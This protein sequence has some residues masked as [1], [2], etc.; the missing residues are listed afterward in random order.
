MAGRKRRRSHVPSLLPNVLNPVHQIRVM[1]RL[2]RRRAK[3]P[4]AAPGTLH[5]SG[6]P[7]I[8]KVRITVLEYGL[9]AFGE[10]HAEAIADVLPLQDR[11]VV[12]WVNVDGLHDLE[13]IRSVGEHLSIH[14]LV[15]EDIVS[16]G[17][18]PKLDEH[19]G[20]LYIVLPMLSLDAETGTVRDEQLSL[21]L[22]PGWV[23]TFQERTGDEFDPV[24]DRIRKL[25]TRIRD[26]GP[27]YLA[28]ALVDAVVDH[29]FAVLEAIGDAAER[30]ELEVVQDPGHD[31]MHRL[32]ALKREMLVVRRAV[33]PVRDTVAALART[34]SALVLD[35][36]RVY[37]RDVYDHTVQIIDTVEVLRDV[38][39]GMIDLYLSSVSNRTNE[40]MKALTIVA[41]VFIPLTFIAGIYGM[42]FEFMPEL[43]WP[44]AYPVL[45]G[46]MVALAL[47]MLWSFKRRGWL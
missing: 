38:V 7:P 8:D 31:T 15:L 28:Y 3:K 42:N 45:L 37:L 32:H 29:Y 11:P 24:R 36:T 21:L 40:I 25:G 18:R 17:Q 22:G 34:D 16:L 13:L 43:E 5:P 26:R 35:Q 1:G 19:E 6:P 12:T 27:D 33:W 30:V 41:S 39:S 2:V 44:W 20:Y 10:R 14:P 23:F 9:D 47:G 4:G 46:V